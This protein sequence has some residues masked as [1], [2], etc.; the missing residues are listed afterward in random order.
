MKSY[1]EN[2]QKHIK[3]KKVQIKTDMPA[4]T[5]KSI[6]CYK[7]ITSHISFLDKIHLLSLLY[8]SLL[9]ASN[10]EYRANGRLNRSVT[11]RLEL[12]ISST[13]NV[14]KCKSRGGSPSGESIISQICCIFE[15]FC[16]IIARPL[17]DAW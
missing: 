14:L 15:H 17:I 13:R 1:T 12:N 3:Q 9:G 10:R 4:N 11:C 16:N 2:T 8:Q 5:S 7:L 6:N